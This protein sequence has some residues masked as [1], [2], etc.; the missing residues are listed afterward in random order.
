MKPELK[1]QK[2]LRTYGL[3][4]T[5][6]DFKILAKQKGDLILFKYNQIESDFSLEEVQE[7][8]GLILDSSNNWEV[9]CYPFKKFFNTGEGFAAKLDW[10]TTKVYIKLDGSIITLYNYKNEWYCSTSGV[11]DAD[12]SSNELNMTFKDIFWKTVKIQ[13]NETKDEFTSKLDKD[14]FYMFEMCTPFNIVITQHST[15]RIYLIG[16]RSALNLKEIDIETMSDK[17]LIVDSVELKSYEEI[18]KTFIDMSWQ[19]EGYVSCDINFNRNKTKNPAYVA[20]HHLKSNLSAYHIMEVI[21]S[22]EIS[23]FC[24]YFKEREEEANFLLNRMKELESRLYFEFKNILKSGEG[25]QDQKEYALLI[26]SEIKQEFRG[27]MFSLKKN[28]DLKI[29]DWLSL[30]DDRWLYEYLN[31][32]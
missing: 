30:Q 6:E 20:C 22:N 28:K 29:W 32:F 27:L 8:R 23:E 12:T 4:K 2:Y 25:F 14:K 26:I 31:K 9:V 10:N 1:I 3:D 11:L 15:S 7:C 5:V 24:T 13:Y 19:N 17:L 16:I 18:C 21:K